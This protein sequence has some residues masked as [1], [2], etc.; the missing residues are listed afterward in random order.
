MYS[1]NREKG[2]SL[3]SISIQVKKQ[4][5]I[6]REIRKLYR[7]CRFGVQGEGLGAKGMGHSAEGTG[8]G[9]WSIAQRAKRE[10][11]LLLADYT[12]RGIKNSLTLVNLHVNRERAN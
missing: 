2:N 8:H 5:Y 9:A 10:G 1:E 6:V 12:V 11:E 7:Y 4:L 3:F